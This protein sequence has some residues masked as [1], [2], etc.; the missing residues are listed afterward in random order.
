[1][2]AVYGTWKCNYCDDHPVFETRQKLNEH[3]QKFHPILKGSSWNKGLTKET[4][5]QLAEIYLKIK[6]KYVSRELIP[7]FLGRHHTAKTKAKISLSM[8]KAHLEG[9]AYNIGECRW[10]NEPSWPEKWFMQV[11][12]KEF[13]DKNYLREM[14]FHRFSLDFAWKHKKKCIEI[15]GKQ[16]YEN[17]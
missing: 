7:S 10:N 5:E 12:E 11:I 2:R 1:M 8:K 3:K 6:A 16:H 13:E 9:R 15:D 14:P 4:N 17:V